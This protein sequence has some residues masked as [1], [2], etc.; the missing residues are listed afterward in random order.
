M[1]AT[2]S[3]S[4]RRSPV[5]DMQQDASPLPLPNAGRDHVC[6]QIG[7]FDVAAEYEALR[8]PQSAASRQTGAV[9]MF[10]GLVRDFGDAQGVDSIFLEHYAGMTEKSLQKL[11]AEARQRWPLFEVRIVH[12]VGELRM[13]E[14]IVFVGVSSAHRDAAFAACEFLMDYLKTRAPFWK[15]ETAGGQGR[16]VEQ[17]ATDVARGQRWDEVPACPQDPAAQ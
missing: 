8:R 1:M 7:D 5:A 9:A 12:R 10:V 15:R 11:V 4:F 13:C 3:L 17:K 2:K 6:V 16:W 14:Q